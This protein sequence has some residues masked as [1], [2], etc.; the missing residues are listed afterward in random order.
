MSKYQKVTA[1]KP[2]FP[3]TPPLGHVHVYNNQ[4]F[5]CAGHVVRGEHA[6]LVEWRSH[7][8]TCG[9]VYLTTISSKANCITRRCPKHAKGQQRTRIPNDAIH[10]LAQG[11]QSTPVAKS[12]P[13][14]QAPTAHPATTAHPSYPEWRDYVLAY[15]EAE[16]RGALNFKEWLA[17]RENLS[18]FD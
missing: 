11:W 3:T 6:P 4:I 2:Y 17:Q 10:P 13:A 9:A 5:T 15:P 18:Q 1:G 16:R 7:C 8:A 14:P 12:K